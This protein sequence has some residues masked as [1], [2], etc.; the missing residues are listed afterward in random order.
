[1]PNNPLCKLLG[2][3]LTYLERMG[4]FANTVE[5]IPEAK[6]YWYKASGRGIENEELGVHVA[7]V[8]PEEPE[9]H[10]VLDSGLHGMEGYACD[11]LQIYVLTKM[12][13][14]LLRK[15][16]R[17]GFLF[18]HLIVPWAASWFCRT[19]EGFLPNW[20][21]I[22]EL[23]PHYDELTHIFNPEKL[24]QGQL[25]TRQDVLGLGRFIT[26]HGFRAVRIAAHS[27]QYIR[28]DW[29]QFGGS[30]PT[31]TSSILQD[32]IQKT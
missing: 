31:E 28:K 21:Q 18:P 15:Y 7:Y 13:P 24:T 17:L 30:G 6:L 29:V 20:D 16:P 3:R 25:L 5:K 12:M 19:D 11:D 14:F 8:G 1:M 9:A 27:G 23:P 2:G 32:I 4:R 10:L 22:P 26:K